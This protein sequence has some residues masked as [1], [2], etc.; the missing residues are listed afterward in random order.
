MKV[1]KR[2]PK[3]FAETRG[4][5]TLL[6]QLAEGGLGLGGCLLD[7]ELVEGGNSALHQTCRTTLPFDISVNT[8]TIAPPSKTTFLR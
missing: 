3:A 2:L 5:G 8:R 4:Q 6:R 1:S 7:P